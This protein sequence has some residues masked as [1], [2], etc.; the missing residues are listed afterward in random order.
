M[1]R[2]QQLK[3]PEPEFRTFTFPSSDF[4]KNKHPNFEIGYCSRCGQTAIK[5]R[6]VYLTNNNET[7]AINLPLC[8]KHHRSDKI[9]TAILTT[10]VVLAILAAI[11]IGFSGVK[12][13]GASIVTICLFP[14]LLGITVLGVIALVSEKIFGF[15]KIPALKKIDDK[16]QVKI[17]SQ[18]YAFKF[19]IINNV[20][21]YGIPG[22]QAQML[23]EVDAK[24]APKAPS[25]YQ[26]PKCDTCGKKLDYAGNP[27]ANLGDDNAH[28]WRGTVC[29]NCRHIFCDKCNVVD[30]VPCPKCS[31]ALKPTMV[32]YLRQAGKL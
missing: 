29:L 32:V 5:Q 23:K 10:G 12:S 21:I 31:V 15:S 19:E 30:A 28:T 7:I 9:S 4:Q 25:Q 20:G 8:E 22:V 11:W 13:N 14:S 18:E 3:L 26:S 1:N 16:I 24:I 27:L 17:Y 6:A 2:G